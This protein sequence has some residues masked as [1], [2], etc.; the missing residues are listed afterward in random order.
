MSLEINGSWMGQVEINGVERHRIEVNGNLVYAKRPLAFNTNLSSYSLPAG[1]SASASFTPEGAYYFFWKDYVWTYRNS[2]WTRHQNDDNTT[3]IGTP[4]ISVSV[5]DTSKYWM[6]A[7]FLGWYTDPSDGYGI[8]ITNSDG[9]LTTDGINFMNNSNN[10]P[11][12]SSSSGMDTLYLYAH[13]EFELQLAITISGPSDASFYYNGGTW[14]SYTE[15]VDYNSGVF[16]L[17][18]N[19]SGQKWISECCTTYIPSDSESSSGWKPSRDGHGFAGWGW[20]YQPSNLIDGT[21]R[22]TEPT[23]VYACYRPIAAWRDFTKDNTY[24]WQIYGAS[25]VPVS[26]YTIYNDSPSWAKD[27]WT[28]SSSYSTLYFNDWAA[29]YLH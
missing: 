18:N 5:S 2:G 21:P 28:S 23:T 6:K 1:Y 16:N 12:R 15:W 27:H 11:T 24:S 22:F 14:S 19:V 7:S 4:S 3:W 26:P 13:W 25:S 17:L 20:S 29:R 10:Y 8:Q 9:D